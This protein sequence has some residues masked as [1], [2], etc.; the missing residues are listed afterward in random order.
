MTVTVRSGPHQRSLSTK[1][2]PAAKGYARSRRA[3]DQRRRRTLAP[4]VRAENRA[5]G[6]VL[7]GD[8]CSYCMGHCGQMAADHIVALDQGGED[9][10]TNLTAAGRPCNAAKKA[11][12]LLLFLLERA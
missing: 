6:A 1:T 10:A 5:Y 2:A 3:Y 9:A 4:G 12:P 8:P 7:R 11:R